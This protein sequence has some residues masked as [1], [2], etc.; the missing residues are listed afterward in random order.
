MSAEPSGGRGAPRK[1]LYI[2]NDR[3]G[4]TLLNLPAA[5]ALKAGLPGASLTVLAHAEVAP[6]LAI[7]PWID[8]VMADEPGGGAWWRRAATLARRLRPRRF[9]LAVISNP[10]KELHA[11]AWLARIPV[12]VGYNRK[13]GR[14]LLTHRIEDRKALGGRHE[15][16]YNLDLV[17]ALGLPAA[18][19]RWP[20]P[21]Q[22]REQRDVDQILQSS[23][24]QPS[25]PFIALHPWTSHPSKQW[26]TDR[27]VELGRRLDRE[28]GL[29]V[30][31]IGGPDERGKAS[32]PAPLVDLVG[33]CSLPQS[34]ALLRRAR[35]L[36]SNDSGPAHLAAAVGTPV[37]GLFSGAT[38]AGPGRWGPWGAG[39]AVI[40]KDSMEQISVDD[41]LSAVRAQLTANPSRR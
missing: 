8:D 41:V 1:L 19:P 22:E 4:E 7:L 15:A 40:A 31:V 24:L 34:A 10:K 37:L 30:A 14:W 9:D 18:D 6:L 29:R 12:R 16:E 33:R 5:A 35:L 38:A 13:L 21:A 2:R 32:F 27:F 25:E 36:V 26:P 11:A 17:R 3:L 28:L 20:W 23:A 39:H